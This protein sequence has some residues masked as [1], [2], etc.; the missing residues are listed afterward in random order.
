MS[1]P[2]GAI[3][4]E[5]AFPAELLA[6]ETRFG[7]EGITTVGSGDDLTLV[8][9]VQREWKDDPKGQ[10]KLLAYKPKAKEWS[11]VRYPLEAPKAAGW[12]CRRSPRTMASS[13]SSSATT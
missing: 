11:A 13:A 3:D 2:K 5:I 12:A 8:M 4:Q 6:G 1:T 7:L 10:V 9:A